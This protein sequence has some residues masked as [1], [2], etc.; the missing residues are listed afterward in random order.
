M[1]QRLAEG[2]SRLVALFR[3]R[4]LDRHF[5]EELATHI[6]LL[7]ERYGSA[8]WPRLRHGVRPS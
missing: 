6:D 8:G 3:R 4:A 1:M 2:L 5:D 7:T